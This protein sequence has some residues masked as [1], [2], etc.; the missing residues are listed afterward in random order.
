MKKCIKQ[1]ITAVGLS[2]ISVSASA[3]VLEVSNPIV[4]TES[5]A[6]V[7][8]SMS[9]VGDFVSAGFIVTVPSGFSV[10]DYDAIFDNHEV[11][12]NSLESNSA[13]IAVYSLSNM[14]FDNSENAVIN[15]RFKVEEVAAGTYQ[16]QI[17]A[18][19]FASAD[20]VLTK[21][22]DVMF[23]IDVSGPDYTPGDANGDGSITVADYIAI[24]HYIMGTSP[25]NFNE[26]AADANGDGQINVAD[27]IA[28]AHIIMN[29]SGK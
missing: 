26:Q 25:A 11:R 16:G 1:I 12:V 23:S 6:N 4:D 17:T 3:Q 20:A 10:I 18:V 22:P 7:E 15:F 28:V 21:I 27:Y 19:E 14:A 24:A 9:G 29:D 13:K 5:V 8:I 2:F